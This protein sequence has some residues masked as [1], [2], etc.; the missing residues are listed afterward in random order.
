MILTKHGGTRDQVQDRLYSQRERDQVFR[1][2]RFLHES[3][4][5]V[6]LFAQ[7]VDILVQISGRPKLSRIKNETNGTDLFTVTH[8]TCLLQSIYCLLACLTK[9][10]GAH[11]TICYE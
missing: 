1:K 5:F 7:M 4:Q 11:I 8:V 9:L 3:K 10:K 2:L 6:D